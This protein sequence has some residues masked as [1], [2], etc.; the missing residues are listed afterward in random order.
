MIYRSCYFHT[1]PR[2]WQP[3]PFASR[4][5]TASPLRDAYSHRPL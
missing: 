2:R 4:S 3:P 1:L 5:C